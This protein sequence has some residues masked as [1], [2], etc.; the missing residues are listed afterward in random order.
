VKELTAEGEALLGF[1]EDD[2]TAYAVH[3]APPA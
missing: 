2:A 1:A 3:I